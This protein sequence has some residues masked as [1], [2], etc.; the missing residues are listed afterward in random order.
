[1]GTHICGAGVGTCTVMRMGAERVE[2]ATVQRRAGEGC[3]WCRLRNS[4]C[5]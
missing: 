3:T 4:L 5:G 2:L 1:V